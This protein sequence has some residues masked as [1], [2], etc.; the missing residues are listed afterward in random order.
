MYLCFPISHHGLRRDNFTFTVSS[1]SDAQGNRHGTGKGLTPGTSSFSLLFVISSVLY[2]HLSAEAGTARSK[3]G[4]T[5]AETRFCLPPE[6][7]SPFKLTGAS[8]QSTAGSRGVRISVNNAGYTTFLGNV[9][10]L[11][12]HSIGQFPLHFPSRASPCA[13]RFQL[14]STARWSTKKGH[15]TCVTRHSIDCKDIIYFQCLITI[16]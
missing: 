7:T 14:D 8:F 2:T 9:R 12:T 11:A 4:G 3:P 16:T 10:V 15:M 13:V 6:R 5:R 1:Q